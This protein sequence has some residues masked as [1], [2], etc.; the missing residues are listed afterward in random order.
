[1]IANDAFNNWKSA[2]YTARRDVYHENI[3][4]LQRRQRAHEAQIVQLNRQIQVNDS[5]Q[6][7]LQ[8]KLLTQS[9]KVIANFISRFIHSSQARG[10]YTWLEALKEFKTRRRF[11][12]STVQYWIKNNQARAFRHWA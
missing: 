1:M 3:G 8:S 7:H 10:F 9:H 12:K 4:E 11:L 6:H 5:T 2:H